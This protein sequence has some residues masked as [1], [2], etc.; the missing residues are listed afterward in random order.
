MHT[1]THDVTQVHWTVIHLVVTPYNIIRVAKPLSLGR[2]CKVI[3]TGGET[4]CQK[5]AA[6]CQQQPGYKQQGL[7]FT[8]GQDNCTAA[9]LSHIMQLIGRHS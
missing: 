5:P 7:N 1:H 4:G 8:A 6:N 2:E 9:F 3:A